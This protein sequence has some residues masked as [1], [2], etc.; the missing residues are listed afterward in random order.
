MPYEWLR[1]TTTNQTGS[2]E[3][4][5]FSDDNLGLITLVR[6]RRMDGKLF[7]GIMLLVCLKHRSAN[8]ASYTRLH[9]V[10]YQMGMYID[11]TED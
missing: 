4:P 2:A 7:K 8:S 10:V 6:L 9:N 1:I 3:S 5:E 11:V